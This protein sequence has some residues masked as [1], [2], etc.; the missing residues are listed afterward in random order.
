M[1]QRFGKA[2]M[3]AAAFMLSAAVWMGSMMPVYAAEN[4]EKEQGDDTKISEEKTAKASEEVGKDETVYVKLNADGTKKEVIVSDWLK[5]PDKTSSIEDSSDLKDI[6]NVKGDETYSESEGQLLWNSTGSD[7]YYQ[8]TTDKDLPISVKITYFLDDKQ[9]TP[10]EIAGKSGKVKIRYEY[11][12]HSK[13]EVTVDGKK[14]TVTTPFAVVTGIILPGNAFTN[15]QV[16]GGRVISDGSNNIVAGMV[17]PGLDDSLDLKN[18]D[19]TKDITLPE[20][21]EVTADVENFH[22]D[23]SATVVTSSI[24]DELGLEDIDTV[25]ELTEALDELSDASTKLVDGS[26]QLL[27]G[28]SQLKDASGEFASGIDTLYEKSGELA[29]GLT[30]LDDSTG[31]LTEG[32]NKLNGEKKTFIDGVASLLDGAAQLVGG[33]GNLTDG[34]SQYTAGAD[35][36]SAGVTAYADGANKVAFGAQDYVAGVGQLDAGIDTLASSAGTLVAGVDSVNE[37]A[38]KLSE[39]AAALPDEKTAQALKA[40]GTAVTEGVGTIHDSVS[41]LCDA[42]DKAEDSDSAAAMVELMS[43]SMSALVQN[44]TV[45]LQ[46]LTDAQSVQ[47]EIDSV[48]G[49]APEAIRQKVDSVENAY[50]ARLTDA[51]SLLNTNIATENAIIEKLKSF[52]GGTSDLE[53]LKTALKEIADKTDPKNPQG[54]YVGAA[55]LSKGTAALLDGTAKLKSGVDNLAAGT[56]ELSKG[57]AALPEG[58]AVLSAGSDALVE[59]G[60]TLSDG[61]KAV[62]EASG[63][64]TEGAKTLTSKSAALNAGAKTLTDGTVSL[65]N[66]LLTLN[67]GVAA[68][69][70]GVAALAEGGMALKEGTGKLSDGGKQLVEGVGT[71]KDGTGQLTDGI[72]KLY[73]GAVELNDGMKTFDTDGIQKLKS[74]VDDEFSGMIDRMKA[75]IDAGKDYQT[76]TKLAEGTK[77]SVKFIIQTEAIKAE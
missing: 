28:V 55:A 26:G 57:A 59:N 12:N 2:G 70:D 60:K 65:N 46:L 30:T 24:F 19:L 38:Q 71:L 23:L 66:G 31:Q 58:M 17:F 32:L 76:F 49:L 43:Q 20:T 63:Q 52:S 35:S 33:A 9:V 75:V 14:E 27:D 11:E 29:D 68:L 10:E 13:T 64:L 54:L 53:Q 62:T 77:G 44:D 5:N 42:L 41:A 67:G 69:S 37:G 56:S 6:K 74:T 36:L 50:A 1:N 25:D 8:G 51:I 18:S 7:I 21:L 3:K 40:A 16:D 4:T 45:V 47:G 22:I 34:I 73:D 61:A 48:K 15:V 72:S 39:G